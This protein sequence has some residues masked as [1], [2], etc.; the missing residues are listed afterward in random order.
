[1]AE[2]ARVKEVMTK[3]PVVATL[4][5]TRTEVLRLLATH[6][7]TGVPV[8]KSDG[9]YAGIVARKHIFEKPEE[10]QLALLVKKDYPHVS[11]DTPVREIAQI[12]LD[13]GLHH[14]AVCEDSKVVG[15]AT[16]A[17][18]LQVVERLGLDTAVDELLQST[19]VPVYEGTPLGTANEIMR[20]ARVFA[21]PVLDDAGRLSGIITDRDIF[22]LSRINGTAV[23]Q[24]LGLA[25]EDN[26]WAWEGLRNVMKLYYEERKV[27]LPQVSVRE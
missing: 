24:E 20:L 13:T 25:D 21:L 3:D 16:P 10:E 4:P 14:V 6:K 2:D 9:T 12:M 7:V 11:P 8:V 15:I 18:L 1:M 19:C 22:D 17:D 23:I 26:P 5:G 27:E